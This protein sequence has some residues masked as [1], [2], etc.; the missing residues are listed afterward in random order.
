[1]TFSQ[2]SRREKSSEVTQSI[3]LMKEPRI[4]LG[5]LLNLDSKPAKLE[6]VRNTK[7]NTCTFSENLRQENW[8][9]K[10][11]TKKIFMRT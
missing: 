8:K 7:S 11:A 6:M 3:S 9:K 1:M 5:A 4:L 10:K 2:R